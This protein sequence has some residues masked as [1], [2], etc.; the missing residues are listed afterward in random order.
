MAG[1]C[2][3]SSSAVGPYAID[4]GLVAAVDPVTTVRILNTNT[5]KMIV[6]DVPV[7][8][9]RVVTQ[10]TYKINGVPGSGAEIKMHFVDPGGAITGK[11]LP[12]GNVIDKI[13]MESGQTVDESIVKVRNR[14]GI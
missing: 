5:K 10:G 8:D 13:K 11:L 14:A 4:K 3:N 9:G 2:G 7:R 6:A 12:T 1:N